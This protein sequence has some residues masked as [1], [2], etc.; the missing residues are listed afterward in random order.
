MA[1]DSSSDAYHRSILNLCSFSLSLSSA[2]S[3]KLYVQQ[4]S[5]VSRISFFKYLNLL[6]FAVSVLINSF[7]NSIK[8]EVARKML[9][10]ASNNHTEKQ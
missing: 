7:H 10:R 6:Q 2:S 5:R 9:K 1:Q 4:V 8:E 3:L